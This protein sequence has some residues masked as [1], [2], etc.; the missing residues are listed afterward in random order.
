MTSCIILL[1][2]DKKM[3]RKTSRK[4]KEIVYTDNKNQPTLEIFEIEMKNSGRR[5]EEQKFFDDS[6]LD[7]KVRMMIKKNINWR[8]FFRL[9][10]NPMMILIVKSVNMICKATVK[11]ILR[12]LLASEVVPQFSTSEF[13]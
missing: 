2:K 4:Q 9:I 7:Y 12:R 1:G 11:T 6:S 8:Q 13:Q 5:K 3:S 10:L